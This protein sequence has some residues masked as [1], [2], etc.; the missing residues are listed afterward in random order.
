[1]SRIS[2]AFRGFFALLSSGKLP[3]DM[4][5]E[6]GLIRRVAVPVTPAKAEAPKAEPAKPSDGAVQLLATLQQESRIVDFLMEDIAPYSDEQVGQAMRGVHEQCRKAL[7]RVM[8]LTPVVDGVEG[9]PTNLAAKGLSNKDKARIKL[10]G[11][12]PPDGKAEAGI[13]R[14]RGWQADKVTLPALKA[15]E[16]ATIVAAA[17]IEIE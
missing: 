15:G 3:D 8:T 12:V 13:L 11:K 9:T 4:V 6:L 14:H 2:L 10:I 7:D 1:M 5:A 16:R 17:E